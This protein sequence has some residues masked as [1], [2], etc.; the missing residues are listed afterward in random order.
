MTWFGWLFIV[1][2]VIEQLGFAAEVNKPR[3]TRTPAWFVIG[4]VLNGLLVLGAVTVG[5]KS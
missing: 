3:P 5:T 2:S 1:L 4:L